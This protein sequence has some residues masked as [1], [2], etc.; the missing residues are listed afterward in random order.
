[1]S[2]KKRISTGGGESLGHNPFAAMDGAAFPAGSRRP[3]PEPVA[4]EKTA[5]K[6]I[7]RGRRVHLRKEKAGRSGKTVTVIEGLET[8]DTGSLRDL[9]ARLRRALG[10]GGALKGKTIELQ[11]DQGEALKAL[12]E[13]EGF[14]GGR[15]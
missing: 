13:K 15:R 11:G 4:S 1:M 14:G 10:V 9:T 12:L 3:G 8:L 2:E 5:R 7:G 6:P